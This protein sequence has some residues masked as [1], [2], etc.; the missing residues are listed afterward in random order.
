VDAGG[1]H[2]NVCSHRPSGRDLRFECHSCEPFTSYSGAVALAIVERQIETAVIAVSAT[3]EKPGL[4]TLVSKSRAT[5][6]KNVPTVALA[7][8]TPWARHAVREGMRWTGDQ[9]RRY[10]SDRSP[11][12]LPRGN[13]GAHMCRLSVDRSFLL[14]RCPTA[15]RVA[16]PSSSAITFAAVRA[17]YP[18]HLHSEELFYGDRFR[19]PVSLPALDPS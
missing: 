12:R 14:I 10:G 18:G 9:G 7:P 4:R 11:V 15:L 6:T 5:Q 8:E 3:I 1:R 19:K 2:C 17:L 16:A 13:L